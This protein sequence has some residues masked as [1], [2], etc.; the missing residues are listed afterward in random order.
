MAVNLDSAIQTLRG[1]D[2]QIRDQVRTPT[3]T[4]DSALT[5][6]IEISSVARQGLGGIQSPSS[7]SLLTDLS[8][9]ISSLTELIGDS[10]GRQRE[11]SDLFGD[12]NETDEVQQRA[13]ELLDGYFN[14]ENTAERIFNF[15]FSFFDGTQD[16]E[17]FA[18]ARLEN[19]Y[20]GFRQAEEALGG[21]ADISLQTRDR[22][23]ELVEGFINEG[24]EDSGT[25]TLPEQEI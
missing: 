8:A 9:Q 11:L 18:Q 10:S 6:S 3:R 22:I 12:P 2:R 20:E 15:A 17:E 7:A 25:G 23:E 14:V 5:D 24:E 4:R 19:I 16:R 13:Q 1:I 21:L